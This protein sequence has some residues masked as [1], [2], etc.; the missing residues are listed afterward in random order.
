MIDAIASID[1]GCKG[2]SYNALRVKPLAEMK[3]EVKLL[4]DSYISVWN[5]TGGTIMG[6]R[7]TDGG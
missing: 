6:D 4:I 7:W 2:S 3:N 5:D 1:F